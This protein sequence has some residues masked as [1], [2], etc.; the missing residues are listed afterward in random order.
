VKAIKPDSVIAENTEGESINVP[1]DWVVLARGLKP[2]SA[3]IKEL[4]GYEVHVIGDCLKPRRIYNAI[5]EGFA[6][7]QRI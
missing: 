3:I 6:A 4:E 2:S 5:S 1:A 7:A